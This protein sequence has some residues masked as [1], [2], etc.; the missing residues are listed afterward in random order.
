MYCVGLEFGVAGGAGEGDDVANV[1]HARHEEHQALE[2]KAE[3]AVGHGAEASGV[4]IPPHVLHGYVELLDACEQL[5]VV[6]LALAA[7]DDFA[8][9]G[10]ED[11]HRAHGA[12]VVVLLHV[13]GLDV[14]RIVG[15]NHRALEVLLHEVALMLALEVDAPFHRELELAAR[16][17][18]DFNAF[19]VGEALEVVVE[20]ELEALYQPL[21]E[22]FGEE[23]D[24]VAAVVEGILYAVLHEVFGELHVVVDV[25]EG[26]LGLNHP[27]L[28]EVARGVGVL[29]TEGRAECVDGAECRSAEL[30]LELAAHGECRGLAEEVLGVV[31]VALLVAGKVGEGQR[32]NL[33]HSSGALA[34]AGGDEGCVE[35]EESALVEELMDGESQCRAYSQHG[36]EGGGAGA[37]VGFLAE[38]FHGVALLLQGVCLGVG[39]AVDF[40]GVGLHLAALAFALALDQA[41]GDV[42]GRARGDGA[43]VVVGEFGE[44]EHYLEVLHRRAVVESHEL[45]VLVAATCSYPTFYIDFRANERRV[46]NILYLCACHKISN[47]RQR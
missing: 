34:V 36:A 22:V 15:E 40:E 19:G 11:V 14:A 33:E 2:A 28:R 20:H 1:G 13:E 42:D 47:N 17:F 18:E 23:V 45:H 46:E 10:E 27:E 37:Q 4:E 44:V 8:D 35:I 39:G 38:K 16:C 24:V 12:A 5:V 31:N 3:A 9:V 26:Y 43:K 29:G 41:A 32:R 6:G 7:A 21:V 25:V 30:A